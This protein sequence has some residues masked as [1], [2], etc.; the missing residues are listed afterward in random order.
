MR[1]SLVSCGCGSQIAVPET[2]PEGGRFPCP[3]CGAELQTPDASAA[4]EADAQGVAEALAV[5]PAPGSAP[6]VVA[7]KSCP[8][9]GE[10]ILAAALKCRYCNE[11]LEAPAAAGAAVKAR[12][13][14]PEPA[15]AGAEP[16]PAEYFVAIV[17]A[18]I[19]LIIGAVWAVQRKVKAGKM[20]QASGLGVLI[21][22]VAGLLYYVYF[23]RDTPTGPTAGDPGQ[24]DSVPQ[25]SYIIPE[26]EGPPPDGGRRG[27]DRF[28]G[29]GGVVD[30]DGQPPEI[31]RAMRANVRIE[32]EAGSGSG[33]VVQRDPDGSVL[34]ITNRHVIDPSFTSGGAPEPNIVPEDLPRTRITYFNEQSNPASPL[35]VAP[36]G[37]D[38]AILRA[39]A[40]AEVE[41]VG[42]LPTD[43]ILAGQEVFAVGN[44]VGLGWTYTRGVVSAL[45]QE[46][47]GRRNVPIIQTDTSITY[48][49]SGGGLY[50]ARGELI[51]IN[52]SIVD[53]R[54]GAGLG[55]AIRTSLLTDLQPEG[56][57]M[58]SDEEDQGTA[59]IQ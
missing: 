44:P 21:I 3:T 46:R 48:G 22:S 52:S 34:V 10:Q 19:G 8:F 12:V 5:E 58:P 37:I 30:L 42:W 14:K 24:A 45:R 43:R 39:P 50:N 20:L 23:V 4:V 6:A 13:Q 35:W 27:A 29:M 59:E 32:G 56:L 51:G 25:V 53:P 49:N 40:P 33:V 55:F 15:A 16:N 2:L 17:L 11:F 28:G 1:S 31:Q 18:P 57:Q 36:E 7:M 54:V 9:C 38:L 41:P 26:W 47:F